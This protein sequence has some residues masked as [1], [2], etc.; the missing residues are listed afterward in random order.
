MYFFI[1]VRWKNIISRTG[2]KTDDYCQEPSADSQTAESQNDQI[3]ARQ[4]FD[5]QIVAIPN[6]NKFC[7]LFGF[8]LGFFF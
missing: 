4:N 8:F 6:A 1:S 2:I 7:L 5:G 3:P